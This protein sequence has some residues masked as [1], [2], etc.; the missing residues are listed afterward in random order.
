MWKACPGTVP[1]SPARRLFRTANSP[2]T[3]LP[4]ARCANA[5]GAGLILSDGGDY[6]VI[7][8]AVSAESAGTNDLHLRADGLTLK[9]RGNAGEIAAVSDS[10]AFLRALA[11]ETSGLAAAIE[12]GDTD[13]PSVCSLLNVYRAQGQKA[14]DGLESI[15]GPD[16]TIRRLTTSTHASLTRIDSAIAEPDVGKIKLIHAAACGEWISIVEDFV[17]EE[18]ASPVTSIF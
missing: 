13:L 17:A 7:S 1:K 5:G 12:V 9:L 15:S 2:A 6:C 4:A 3:A 14:L 11:T 10:I 16:S 18:I 8:Q